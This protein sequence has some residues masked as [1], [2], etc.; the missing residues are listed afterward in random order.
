M[1]SAYDNS[2]AL[3]V[4]LSML[5]LSWGT[6]ANFDF[7]YATS[8]PITVDNTSS[9]NGVCSLCSSNHNVGSL[10][11]DKIIIVGIS[12]R[13]VLPFLASLTKVSL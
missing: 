2:R 3:V 12:Q 1:V 10:G 13:Q 11:S 6:F 8:I 4:I 7:A 9:Y 5:L